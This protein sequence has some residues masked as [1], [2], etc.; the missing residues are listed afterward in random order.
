MSSPEGVPAEVCGQFERVALELVG[1]GWFRYS[2][3]AI[4]H[5]IRW[6]MQ[7]ERGQ[8]DFKVNNNWSAPLARWFAA[9]NPE[10]AGLFE[11]RQSYA[12]AAPIR[13]YA[14]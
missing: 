9:R 8:R 6:H 4:L 13:S 1:A 7:V 2:A 5:R 3:D 12:K 10:H 11:T 14:D